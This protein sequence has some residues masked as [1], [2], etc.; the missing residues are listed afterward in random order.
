MDINKRGF[1]L[2]ELLVVVLIIGILAAV[3]LPQ[4]RKVVEKSKMTEAIT[5]ARAIADA[6][7]RYYMVHNTY[8]NCEYT[9]AIDIDLSGSDSCSYGGACVC[10]QTTNF[11]Y[12]TSNQVGSDIA[13]VVRLPK[14][15]YYIYIEKDKPSKIRCSYTGNLDYTPSEVQKQLCDK[16]D[17]NGVL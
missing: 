16:L 15:K 3:A 5:V 9:N 4:Y 1:T 17:E 8:L 11:L 7:Q 6:Q 13:H 14:Y 2:L 12:M 10:K